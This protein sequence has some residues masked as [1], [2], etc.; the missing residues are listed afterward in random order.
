MKL[1]KT[2]REFDQAMD[3]WPSVGRVLKSALN[4]EFKPEEPGLP[5]VIVEELLDVNAINIPDVDWRIRERRRRKLIRSQAV[6]R[7]KAVTE[8]LRVLDSATSVKGRW[9]GVGEACREL[10]DILKREGVIPCAKT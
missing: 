3:T 6:R 2:E 5:E 8:I 10:H 1:D 7:Y 4:L 9:N